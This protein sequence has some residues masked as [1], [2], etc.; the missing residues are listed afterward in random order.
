MD[1]KRILNSLPDSLKEQII[2][3]YGNL[4]NFYNQIFNNE[5]EYYKAFVIEKNEDKKKVLEEYRFSIA[6]K[7]EEMGRKIG[8]DVDGCYIYDQISGDFDEL[9]LKLNYPDVF[10]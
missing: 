6:N 7:L 10:S 4:D 2:L 5:G 3:E 9:L 1:G 8:L